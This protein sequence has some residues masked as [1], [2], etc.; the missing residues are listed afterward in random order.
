[1]KD[2]RPDPPRQP[3]DPGPGVGRAPRREAGI[4]ELLKALAELDA[5]PADQRRDAVTRAIALTRSALAYAQRNIGYPFPSPTAQPVEPRR[6]PASEHV[7]GA[8]A[9]LN[10]ALN[11]L[12]AAGPGRGA[13]FLT[14]ALA[15][16]KA[17]LA[18]LSDPPQ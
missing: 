13:V 11:Q 4:S 1:M 8:T 7:A 6:L 9:S 2:A 14:R 5:I 17:A 15:E 12:S 3:G 18:E 10:R 16:I